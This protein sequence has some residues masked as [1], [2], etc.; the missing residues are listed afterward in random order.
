[1]I[2]VRE[3][4]QNLRQEAAF[5]WNEFRFGV[6]SSVLRVFRPDMS[7]MKGV[8]QLKL[9]GPDGNVKDYRK[10]HNLV[11]T[12]G[13]NHLANHLATVS[14]AYPM[15][16]IAIGTGTIAAAAGDTALGAEV[17]TRVAG[18]MSNPSGAIFR[19]VGTFAAN[20]PATAQAIT[21]SGLFSASSAGT[22]LNRQVF[23]AINKATAD[24]L[25]ITMEITFS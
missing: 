19:V 15:N 7:V 17:G 4:L 9:V 1:M 8:W 24:S 18:T 14:T 6:Y 23:S 22:M 20:N 10:Y 11:V 12:A 3:M 25:E 16:N 13:K 21:E 5:Q 2:T